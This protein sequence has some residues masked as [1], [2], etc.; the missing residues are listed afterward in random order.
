MRKLEVEVAFVFGQEVYIKTDLDQQLGQV[1]AVTIRE[2][3]IMYEITRN[4][5]IT[6]CNSFELSIERNDNLL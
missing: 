5:M 1:T 6:W 3:N 4:M 2:G